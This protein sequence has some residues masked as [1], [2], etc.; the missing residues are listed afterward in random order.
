MPSNEDDG[1]TPNPFRATVFFDED[2]LFNSAGSLIESERCGWTTTG[3]GHM[4]TYGD[5]QILDTAAI[6]QPQH[7]YSAKCTG[8]SLV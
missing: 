5:V 3:N 6:F 2:V 8:R 4:H 7:A 1:M